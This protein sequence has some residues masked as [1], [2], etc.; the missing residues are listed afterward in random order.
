MKQYDAV[1]IGGGILGCMA[2]R[3]LRRWHISTALLERE[4]DVCKGI[5]RANSAICYAGYDNKPGSLKA[6]LTV[7]GNANM[8]ALCREL[9][10]PF[11]RCGSLL[12]TYDAK[13]VSRL[14]KKLENGIQNGVPG[15]R[16]LSGAE[17]EAMEPGL[18]TGVAAALYASTTGTVNPWKL[19]IAAFENAVHNGAD[20]FLNTTVTKINKAANGFQIETDGEIFSCKTIFN[21]AGLSADQIQEMIAPP[22]VRLRLDAAEYLV[23]D[24][25]VQKPERIIF[26]QAETCGKGITAIPCVEGNLMISGVRKPLKQAFATTAE[27]LRELHTATKDLLPDVDS[28]QV[29]RSFGAVRPNPYREDG[30]NVGDFCIENPIPGF[31]SLIAIKTPGLTASNEL[32][33]LLAKQGAAYLH[34]EENPH[35]D[36]VRKAISPK[37]EPDYYEIICQCGQV[38]RGEILEAIRRGATTVDGVKRRIGTGMGCCQGSRCHWKIAK[39]L[40]ETGA[41]PEPLF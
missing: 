20:V 7:R 37:A 30:A 6:E 14:E 36:P 38:T 13:A 29:I 1:V 18:K 33:L 23:F 32:A 27:G 10:V 17:A 31:Y 24:S 11:T 26:L 39:I 21:C 9:D 3:N 40:K 35:F 34:A 41:N 8:E 12:V 15:L 4:N 19:G 28:S 22:T 2:A 25:H 5:T 16:L